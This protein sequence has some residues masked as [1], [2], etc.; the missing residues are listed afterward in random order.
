[1]KFLPTLF[2]FVAASSGILATAQDSNNG[3]V[4]GVPSTMTLT[5]F[6]K[7]LRTFLDDEMAIVV[8]AL[9][10]A[11]PELSL[12]SD[13]I[14]ITADDDKRSIDEPNTT[15]SKS[16][17]E[18]MLMDR[19]SLVETDNRG[20][21]RRILKKHSRRH[22]KGKR[23]KHGQY[24]RGRFADSEP[25]S[26]PIEVNRTWDGIISHAWDMA[27]LH[28]APVE[29]AIPG[30][31]ATRNKKTRGR[32]RDKETRSRVSGTDSDNIDENTGEIIEPDEELFTAWS[33]ETET[34]FLACHTSHEDVDGNNHLK[35]ILTAAGKD[36]KPINE[37]QDYMEVVHSSPMLTCVI[38]SMQPTHAFNIATAGLKASDMS[39]ITIVP[40]IDVM[41]I[42]PD[43][44]EQII[45][46]VQSTS[47]DDEISGDVER[48]RGLRNF[49][50]AQANIT[51]STDLESH[52]TRDDSLFWDADTTDNY[53]SNGMESKYVVFS[54][55]PPS[56]LEDAYDV[57][58]NLM[59]MA[60]AG[61]RRRMLDVGN[62]GNERLARGLE[63][64]SISEAF[65]I[66]RMAAN[67]GNDL[68]STSARHWSRMLVSGLEADNECNT[69]VEHIN[70]QTS[71]VKS[72]YEFL[73]VPE[74]ASMNSTTYTACVASVIAGLAVNPR[75]INV[76][77]VPK[78]VELHNVKAQWVLQGSVTAND[79]TTWR[80][81]LFDA[82]LDGNGQIVSVSDTGLDVNNCYFKDASGNG[83]IFSKWDT[84]RRKVVRYDISPRGGD[85]KDA[86]RGH[87]THVV[88]TVSGRHIRDKTLGNGDDPKEGMAPGAKVHFFDIGIGSSVEDPRE[89]WLESFYQDGAGNGAKVASGSW[90][91]GYRTS[92]DWVCR[93]Y[94]QL[95]VDH[96]DVLHVSS[97]GNTGNK[98]DSPF[99]TIGAPAS[100]KNVFA[101]GATNN[102][103]FGGGPSYV[104]DF[105]S[106]GP[107]GDGRTKPDIMAT[108]YAL[109]SA[110]SGFADCETEEPVYLKAGTSMATP[111]KF[112]A[113]ASTLVRQ[114]FS[115]GYYPCGTKGCADPID[116]SGALVKAVLAN[117]SQPLSGVQIGGTTTI[118]NNQNT[119]PYDNTQNMGISNLLTSLPLANENDFNIFVQNDVPIQS[120]Q[121][122]AFDFVL[123][124]SGCSSDFTATL[125]WY[126]P[127]ASNGC[128]K[129]LVNDI[130]LLVENI[131]STTKYYP[132]G[133]SRP[134]RVNNVERVRIKSYAFGKKYRVTV[135][136]NMLGP[137][138][139]E[140][141][142][143]LVV[144]G[145]F[146]AAVL[147]K[148]QQTPETTT[149]TQFR[150]LA[151]T[152]SSNRKQAGNMFA[153]QAKTD[154]IHITSFAVHTLLSGKTVKFHVY[155][156]NTYGGVSGDEAFL[157]DPSAWTRISPTNGIEV[158]AKGF[159]APTII[160][161][162]SFEP[163]AI[164]KGKIQSFYIT[165]IEETEM[166]YKAV[167]ND[168]P[169]G[170]V[171]ASDDAI[172]I[173]SGVGKGIDFGAT[174]RSRQMNGA[175]FYS[176]TSTEN[177]STLLQSLKPTGRPTRRQ[178][179]KLRRTKD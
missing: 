98:F 111:G 85:S 172:S 162:G 103:G 105:S 152:Y 3:D 114:Y 118:L 141:K 144:T 137:G 116:V 79:S 67:Y 41:K 68:A 45:N 81:P 179:G 165:F 129:C 71:F 109:N 107:T 11:G 110:G 48:E 63:K 100:C 73:L 153:I 155:T 9:S 134:D 168:F 51:D 83:N 88:G 72:S 40:W 13:D 119:S 29:K 75:V 28:L 159:G 10:T 42:S 149:T 66:T 130:D 32:G 102:V 37:R 60:K 59:D 84:S 97:A 94:D 52:D 87:G 62:E 21:R 20:N 69:M 55:T 113:G 61:Q 112:V 133:L 156:L 126:D 30:S 106:R 50:R 104:V 174:W 175:V 26:I 145:C 65:S 142:I 5:L 151:T 147:S 164:A 54:L 92:Y 127:P 121:K 89:T 158:V 14:V 157:S 160:P 122:L 150:E 46:I 76:G 44:F 2:V 34:L 74:G 166:L 80:R 57:I 86:F 117:G 135:S 120:G 82:G 171:Y 138:Y 36:I 132:N 177:V 128:T 101:V 178:R 31:T 33:N 124:R 143:S 99:N 39:N 169:T 6:Q 154:G 139:S 77:I 8:D 43:I 22:R 93:L 18:N 161:T 123:D 17:L 16:R 125:A 136:T 1:M 78:H 56:T 38:L 96:P 95:L 108:G 173:F 146:G 4:Q 64:I 35:Q 25:S 131:Q 163:V 15:S 90:G 176:V 91:F 27:K 7:V 58:Q 24:H 167:N 148:D 12:P 19:I 115:Q 23:G 47:D 170:S 140:Q 53:N 49:R 70:L